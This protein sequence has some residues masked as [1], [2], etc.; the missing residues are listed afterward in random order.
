LTIGGLIAL[1]VRAHPDVEFTSSKP[2]NALCAAGK[3]ARTLGEA[4]R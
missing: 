2:I 4:A 3:G 1:T